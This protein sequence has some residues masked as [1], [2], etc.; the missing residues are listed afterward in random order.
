MASSKAT[1]RR[2]RSRGVQ[3]QK[4]GRGPTA[5]LRAMDALFDEVSRNTKAM[6]PETRKKLAEAKDELRRLSAQAV[7]PK[8]R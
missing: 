1:A 7:K 6:S 3:T 5:Y 8:R 2:K 4:P